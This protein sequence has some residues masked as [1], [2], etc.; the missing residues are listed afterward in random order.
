M[1]KKIALEEHFSLPS[2]KDTDAGVL[3]RLT[4]GNY[5]AELG[6]R[7][8]DPALRVAEMDESGVDL[9]VLSLTAPGIQGQP[10][11]RVATEQAVHMNDELFSKFIRPYPNRFAGFAAV[12]LQ[13]AKAAAAELKRVVH[14]YGFKGAMINGYS[15]VL[16]NGA[17]A[18]E[19][20]DS[21]NALPFWEAVA[22]LDIPVYLHPRMPAE[23]HNSIYEGYPVL[24]GSAWGFGIETATHALRL[25]LSGLFER[26]PNINIILGHL[27]ESLPYAVSRIDHR[28]EFHTPESRVG[29]KKTVAE[30]LR[31]NFHFTTSGFCH[32]Q[33]FLTTINEVG[34]DRLLFA[35][36]YPFETMHESAAW[37]E[38]A[39]LNEADR[40]KIAVENARKLLKI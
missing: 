13:D 37:F 16:K 4:H 12:P 25:I 35:S 24:L 23:I 21:P 7:L 33:A 1:I 22:E 31:K 32:D 6:R 39:P 17:P 36:D 20:L 10:D 15:N 26:F 28:L 29:A 40:H 9:S 2:F 8:G 34:A 11:A 27:G 14:D 3:S 38:R 19:Y 5:L 30:Y 18:V